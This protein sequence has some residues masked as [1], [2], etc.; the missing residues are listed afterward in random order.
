MLAPLFAHPE[1][2]VADIFREV[3][4]DVRKDKFTLLWQ[5]YG[6]L[7]VGGAVLIVVVTA[8]I[9]LWKTYSADQRMTQ[10]GAYQNALTLLDAGDAG[11]AAAAFAA[12]A[13]GGSSGYAGA[14]RLRV[15]EAKLAA[16]DTAGAVEVYDAL[17]A[18][19]GV[20]QVWRDLGA[21][22]AVIH[23]MDTASVDDLRARLDPLVGAEA[24][25]RHSAR[26]LAAILAKRAGD[27]ATAR[28]GF[29]ELADDPTAPPGLRARA[30]EVLA[31]MGGG[32][33]A[34]D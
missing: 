28:V 24:P 20:E 15:A 19:G 33:A 29:T 31:A 1:P 16:K 11:G 3:D 23:L 7:V 4:E 26:E 25:W 2:A 30:A 13:E 5:R 9:T 8:A 18:D 34:G 32:A 21:L 6:I 14:V 17:A 22:Y 10:G 12:L 27:L